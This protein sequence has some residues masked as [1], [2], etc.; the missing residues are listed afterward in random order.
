[1]F[2][3]V[4]IYFLLFQGVFC[5]SQNTLLKLNPQESSIN[6]NGSS[7]FHKWKSKAEEFEGTLNFDGDT[8]LKNLNNDFIFISI[9]ADKVMNNSKL[10]NKAIAKA[11]KAKDFPLITFKSTS[12]NLLKKETDKIQ[13]EVIGT[14]SIAGVDKTISALVTIRKTNKNLIFDGDYTLKMSDYNVKPP[15][16][17]F[18]LLKVKDTVNIN[19]HFIFSY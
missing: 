14:L 5:F 8:S 17:L 4:V 19:Y 9:K 12:G 11:L 10:Q 2:K 1:M 18:G 6:L 16:S 3:P 13:L 15:K 7:S